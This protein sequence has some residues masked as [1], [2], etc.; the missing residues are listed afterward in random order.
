MAAKTGMGTTDNKDGQEGLTEE[1]RKE[2]ERARRPMDTANK[3]RLFFLFIAVL[4]LL[5]LYFGGKFWEGVSWF[6]AARRK[7]YAFL[8]WDVLLMLIATFAKM[9]LAVRYNHIVKN[10]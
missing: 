3:F 7:L 9:L 5:F 8:L 10:L 6:E 4:A 1:Q 2:A